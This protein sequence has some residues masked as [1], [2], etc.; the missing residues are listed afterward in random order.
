MNYHETHLQQ[1]PDTGEGIYEKMERTPELRMVKAGI[2][3]MALC[4]V[5]DPKTA[6]VLDIGPAMGW[7]TRYLAERVGTVQAVTLFEEEAFSI[8]GQASNITVTVG[9]MHNL[10]YAWDEQFDLVFAS[11]VLEH[12]PAPF[13]ALSSWIRTLKP[14]GTLFLVLPNA[15]G[16]TRLGTERPARMGSMPGH[17][18]C[19][20]V[21]TLIELIRHAGCSSNTKGPRAEF[22]SYTEVP[23]TCG[24]LVHYMN[25]IWV[26]RRLPC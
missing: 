18:F 1:D 2:I 24:D 23:Q 19:P 17:V 21:D 10:P 15:D 4:R 16:Y 26:A 14:G 20:S 13:V 8:R 12:S 22:V 3:D 9:D 5:E 11:H 6:H 7:E 25:R